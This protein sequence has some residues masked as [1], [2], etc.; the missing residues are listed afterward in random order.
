MAITQAAARRYVNPV[1]QDVATFLDT[2]DDRTV[3]EIELAAGGG[4]PPHRHRSYAERF[5]VLEGRLTVVIDGV[6]HDLEAGGQ[7]TA[8]PMARH[9]FA[10]ATAERTVF[11]VE[12]RPGHPGFEKAI[13]VAYGLAADGRTTRK[14]IPRNP[15]HTALILAWSDMLGPG[16][17]GSSPVIRAVASVARALGVERRLERRY[18]AARR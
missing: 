12:L 14:A 15:L 2:E 1:I 16:L 4:N 17:L 5:T 18:P 10:N 3:V 8:P 6:A 11:R 13:R 9:N 7:A